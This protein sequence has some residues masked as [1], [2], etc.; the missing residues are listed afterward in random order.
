M[1]PKSFPPG[2]HAP[3]I[4]F[5]QNTVQQEI[6]WATQEQHLKHLIDAGCHGGKYIHTYQHHLPSS[7]LHWF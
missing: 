5:F 4:T 3:S 2:I 1:S 6:D 7:T